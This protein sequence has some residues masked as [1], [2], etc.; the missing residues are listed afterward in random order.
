MNKTIPL[1]ITAISS[2]TAQLFAESPAATPNPAT[3]ITREVQQAMT[4]EQA[5]ERLKAGNQRFIDDK[6]VN[7]DYREQ[8]KATAQGQFPYAVILACQDSRTSS[9][10]LFDMSKGDAFHLRVAGN[11]V[12]DDI[13]GGIEFGTKVVG[14]KIIVVMGHTRC[15]AIGGAV[16]NV[17]LGNL[18]GLLWKIQPSIKDVDPSITPRTGSNYA[19]VDKVAEANVRTMMQQ[20][21]AKSPI[22]DQQIANKEISLVGAMCDVETGKVTF[23][24]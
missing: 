4:P 21:R 8:A 17:E 11:I 16:D 14:S 24:E 2:F 1:L 10:I 19:F 23:L 5:L 13:L 18:T 22:I 20:V 15:G 9:E 7:R 12:N 3:V 6:M